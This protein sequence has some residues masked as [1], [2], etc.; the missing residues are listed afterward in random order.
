MRCVTNSMGILWLSDPSR[1]TT[2][3]VLGCVHVH[4]RVNVPHVQRFASP[5]KWLHSGEASPLV[6]KARKLGSARTG[7]KLS[8]HWPESG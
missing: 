1:T 5:I 2:P 6:P 3:I 4:D 7:G 8:I